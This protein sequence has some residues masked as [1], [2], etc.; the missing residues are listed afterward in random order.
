M[1]IE[2]ASTPAKSTFVDYPADE[3]R[4]RNRCGDFSRPLNFL[5][6]I[7]QIN[8]LG[9]KKF[10]G[11]IWQ[12]ALLRFPPQYGSL[13]RGKHKDSGRG[14]EDGR[15]HEERPVGAIHFLQLQHADRQ[16]V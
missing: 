4:L 3:G 9:R 16:G 12:I 6:M 13:E 11:A 14:H 1:A 15:G 10:C 5:W 2:I 8:A 7:L